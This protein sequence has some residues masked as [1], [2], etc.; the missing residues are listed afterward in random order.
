MRVR[1][2]ATMLPFCLF[3]LIGCTFPVQ[4]QVDSLI[5]DR[6]SL[7][8]DVAPA[9]EDKASKLEKVQGQNKQEGQ[10][11]TLDQ[12]L[13]DKTQ[14][15]AFPGSDVKDIFLDKKATNYK[16][17]IEP[18]IK[19]NYPSPT[20]LP[21]D[22]DFPPGPDGRPLSLSDLQRIGCTNNPLLRQAASDIEAARGQ[23]SKP[24]LIRIRPSAMPPPASA[25]AAARP[26][27]A[28][29]RK[30]SKPS[31]SLNLPKGPPRKI[32]VL[33]SL[34]FAARKPT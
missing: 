20:P 11:P 12:R 25:Q 1:T 6:S 13:L 9:G 16:D 34:P 2:R 17:K 14:P 27:A 26:S 8:Y 22:K 21:I 31:A 3:F 33:L 24:A 19:Q 32:C 30:P 18:V 29:S 15:G 10:K 28:T 4:Q 5:C 7:N 23:P